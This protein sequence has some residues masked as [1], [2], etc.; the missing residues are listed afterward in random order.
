MERILVVPDS[1]VGTPA[2]AHSLTYNWPLFMVVF[3]I[4]TGAASTTPTAAP[5]TVRHLTAETKHD[6]NEVRTPILIE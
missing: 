2:S 3:A 4:T 5:Y 1:G 6:D